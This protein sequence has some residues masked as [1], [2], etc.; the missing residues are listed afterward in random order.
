MFD[1]LEPEFAD[2][3]NQEYLAKKSEIA[4]TK[5]C[6]FLDISIPKIH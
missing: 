1:E 4:P 3:Q 6:S 2:L 5:R